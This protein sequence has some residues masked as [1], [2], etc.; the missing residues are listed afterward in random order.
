MSVV[1]DLAQRDAFATEFSVPRETMDALD[2][3]VAFLLDEAQRQNLISASTIEGLWTRHVADS[4]QL[5]AL[6]ED[7]EG[8][9][10]DLGSG[11]G[12]P[13][14]IAA[15]MTTRP[16][17]LIE[18]R[19]KRVEFLRAAAGIIGAADRVTVHHGRA[20]TAPV[21]P[22]AVISARAFAPLDRLLPIG[23]RFAALSTRWVLPK[24][25]TAD[26]ELAAA[27]SAWQGDF[28]VVQS[29]T[30]PEASIIVADRVERRKRR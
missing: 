1:P 3:F 26:M 4:A 16:V 24:G 14:I 5:L 20:E 11:A 8:S 18:S 17:L 19:A 30:D 21:S 7:V 10:L 25:R 27:R 9:W 15:A 13:G 6:A 12:F 2:R 28:R 22:V 29:S 23:E